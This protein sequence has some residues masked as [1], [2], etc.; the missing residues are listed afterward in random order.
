MRHLAVLVLAASPLACL[1]TT[2]FACQSNDQCGSDGMCEL[3]T[4]FCSF[5]DAECPMGRRYGDLSGPFAGKC[6]G[7]P[8]GT[9]GGTEG[10]PGDGPGIDGPPVTDCKTDATYMTIPSGQLGHTYRTLVTPLM[11]TQQRDKCVTEGATLVIPDDATELGAIAAF[12]AAAFWVG[13]SDQGTENTFLTVLGAPATFLPWRAGQPDDKNPGE[14]CV[15]ADNATLT[16]SDERCGN[17][18]RAVCECIP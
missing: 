10:T 14:D 15:R 18:A 2:S 1:R 9:D 13:V 16:Y 5:A 12:S 6:V 17:T 11:W 4:G 3:A 8:V 7:E